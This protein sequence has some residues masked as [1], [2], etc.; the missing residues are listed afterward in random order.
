MSIKINLDKA[1][2]IAHDKRRT[3]R[4][5]EFKPF[6]EIIMKQIPNNDLKIAEEER[7][8]IRDKYNVVQNNINNANNIEDLSIILNTLK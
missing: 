7:Q 3:K 8:K 4:L 6:D 2:N 1:K 5:E